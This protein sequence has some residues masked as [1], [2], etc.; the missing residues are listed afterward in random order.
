MSLRQRMSAEV[1]DADPVWRYLLEKVGHTALIAWALAC[2]LHLEPITAAT[3]ATGL[4]LVLGKVLW[5]A[6]HRAE[7]VWWVEAKD[8]LFDGL[9]SAFVIV[10]ALFATDEPRGMIALSA[11][12]VL[13][14]VLDNNGWGRPS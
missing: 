3:I 13:F 2:V 14:L 7:W 10:L 6:G 5:Y 1:G 12:I 4:Y 9:V 11:W 8:T